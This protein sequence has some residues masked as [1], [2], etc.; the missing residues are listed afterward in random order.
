MLQYTKQLS[1]Y[2]GLFPRELLRFRELE[3]L[4][5]NTTH[6]T[7]VLL[8]LEGYYVF[9]KHKMQVKIAP[10]SSLFSM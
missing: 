2:L 9:K 5:K 8:H 3:Q 10:P 7:N 6:L 4:L 1:L